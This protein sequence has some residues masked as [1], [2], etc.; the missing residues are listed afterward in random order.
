M[1]KVNY[2]VLNDS[3]VLNFNGKT[4]MIA[5]SDKRYTTVL[6]IIRSQSHAG[7]WQETLIDLME[8]EIT[9][10]QGTG[11][12]LRDGKLWDGETAL[13]D[14]LTTR[15]L[16]FRDLELPYQPLLNFWANL[17]ANPS[18]NSRQMLYKFL[19][20]NGHPLTE[21]GSFIAYRGVREDFK[22]KH[23]GKFDNSP[24]QVCEMARSEVDDNPD[25]TCSSGLHVACFDYAKGFGEKLVE[26]KVN[27]SDVVAVPR[28]YNGTKMRVCKFEVI[29]ECASI[30]KEE[31]YN[32]PDS[33]HDDLDEEEDLFGDDEDESNENDCPGCGE[34]KD[35]F[36]NYCSQCGEAF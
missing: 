29:Q 7:D 27:P 5:G 24:G 22:D 14:A 9:A 36:A 23:S 34:E 13:P 8:R 28:D 33:V 18:F 2:H 35:A 26:V 6:N 32:N 11:L 15:I 25:N 10:F 20:H 19:E 30:R 31:I 12:D 17:K 16:K 1:N 3:I 21:D 4:E